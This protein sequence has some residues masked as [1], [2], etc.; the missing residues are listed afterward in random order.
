MQQVF[1]VQISTKINFNH[2]FKTIDNLNIDKLK[3]FPIYLNK[4]SKIA[5][6]DVVKNT[7]YDKLAA[8]VYNNVHTSG[9][10]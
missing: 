5:K 6:N 7:V 8:K 2:F 9:F 10:V 4:L 3:R 1:I